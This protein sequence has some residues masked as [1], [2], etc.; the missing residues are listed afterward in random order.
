MGQYGYGGSLWGW[1][2]DKHNNLII[3][4]IGNETLYGDNDTATECT[5]GLLFSLIGER[6]RDRQI[7]TRN[8]REED[9]LYCH[10]W[11]QET[12]HWQWQEI[13]GRCLGHLMW[14]IYP[15]S[16][17]NVSLNHF[18]NNNSAGDYDRWIGILLAAHLLNNPYLRT[19]IRHSRKCLIAKQL[20]VSS[21][22][23]KS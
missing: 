23:S 9:H 5:R 13:K 18:V 20:Y 7:E 4:W 19:C 10:T 16:W 21:P 11:R 17:V 12:S 1:M 6:K 2:C 3:I 22:G 8:Y 15:M 14:R